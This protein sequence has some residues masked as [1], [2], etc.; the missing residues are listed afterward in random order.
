ML[1]HKQR[2]WPHYLGVS[3]QQKVAFHCYMAALFWSTDFF[4]FA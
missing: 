3:L 2:K 4:V 1:G